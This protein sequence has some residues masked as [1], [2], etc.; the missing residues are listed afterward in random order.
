[1]KQTFDL[2]LYGNYRVVEAMS[3][4]VEDLTAELSILEELYATYES[5]IL[6]GRLFE[7]QTMISLVNEK[8]IEGV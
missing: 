7:L 1:M 5:D 8:Y 4:L 3:L 6:T 2:E